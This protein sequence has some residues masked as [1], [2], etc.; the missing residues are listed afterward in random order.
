V[1]YG[2]PIV[3]ACVRYA[4]NHYGYPGEYVRLGVAAFNQRTIK[5]YERAGFEIYDRAMGKIAGQEYEGVY[6]RRR[7]GTE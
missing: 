7:L 5:A 1:R 3:R 6:M 2:L 4:V